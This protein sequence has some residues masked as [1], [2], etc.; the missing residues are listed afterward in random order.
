MCNII[1]YH[2]NSKFILY[3]ITIYPSMIASLIQDYSCNLKKKYFFSLLFSWPK[4]FSLICNSW[5]YQL[6][7]GSLKIWPIYARTC[8]F[9]HL[10]VICLNWLLKMSV[11]NMF[12]VIIKLKLIQNCWYGLGTQAPN[13]SG[14]NHFKKVR[15]NGCWISYIVWYHIL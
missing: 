10:F 6:L 1:V 7:N 8:N 13:N 12:W 11:F 9:N 14:P 4:C 15:R 3:N 2:P 5:F